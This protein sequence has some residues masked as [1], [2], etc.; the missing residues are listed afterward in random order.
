MQVFQ[1]TKNSHQHQ[2]WCYNEALTIFSSDYSLN[3][4]LEGARL[5]MRCAVPLSPNESP[6]E[7]LIDLQAC[8]LPVAAL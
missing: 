2:C 7:V 8:D 3:L 4:H 1:I 5:L 6:T